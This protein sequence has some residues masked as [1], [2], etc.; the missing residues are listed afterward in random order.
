MS[1]FE[2]KFQ[3]ESGNATDLVGKKPAEFKVSSDFGTAYPDQ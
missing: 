2:L 3:S 1:V